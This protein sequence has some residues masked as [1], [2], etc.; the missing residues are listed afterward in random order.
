MEDQ[1]HSYGLSVSSEVVDRHFLK[2]AKLFTATCKLSL[3]RVSYMATFHIVDC[4]RSIKFRAASFGP[5][6]AFHTTARN[7]TTER[8]MHHLFQILRSDRKTAER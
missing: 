8:F 2:Y 7:V 5:I 3:V 6:C 4:T 1:I